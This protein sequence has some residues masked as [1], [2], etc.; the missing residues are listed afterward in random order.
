[1]EVLGQCHTHG[2]H[3]FCSI[4]GSMVTL[5]LY[6]NP[7]TWTCY[8]VWRLLGH[9]WCL[10]GS[11]IWWRSSGWQISGLFTKPGPLRFCSIWN[12]LLPGMSYPLFNSLFREIT[13]DFLIKCGTSPPPS[14]SILIFYISSWYLSPS[15]ITL[16]IASMAIWQIQASWGQGVCVE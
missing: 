11:V 16:Y 2:G 4:L 10:G 8:V 3:K 12:V 1:M 5:G 15:D 9:P 7:Q 6:S 14:F 13:P